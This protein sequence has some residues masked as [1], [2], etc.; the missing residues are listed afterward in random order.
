MPIVMFVFPPW[1]EKVYPEAFRNFIRN[2]K[3]LST[4]FDLHETL[5]DILRFTGAELDDEHFRSKNPSGA[6]GM[7]LFKKVPENRTCTDAAIEP[8]WCAC[9]QWRVISPETPIV[10]RAAQVN[11]L[12][13]ITT[14]IILK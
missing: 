11:T 12:L 1:F 6:R 14:I 10:Q 13:I 4:P 3:I 7:S 5:Q 8:H 9:L 2:T